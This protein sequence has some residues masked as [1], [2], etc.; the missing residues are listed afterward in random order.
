[1]HKH[2]FLTIV[3]L[4]VPV[5]CVSAR[6]PQDLAA[7]IERR[8]LCDHFRGEIPEPGD[9]ARMDEVSFAIGE[10]CTGTDH[11]LAR[12]GRKYAD[13]PTLIK[14]LSSYED[15]IEMAPGD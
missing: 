12:L 1:M 8:D 2:V 3:L 7:F 13:N 5:A 9:D 15:H 4:L 6:I 11:E 14:L 10:Y